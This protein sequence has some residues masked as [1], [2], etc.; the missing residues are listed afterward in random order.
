MKFSGEVKTSHKGLTKI[1]AQHNHKF[2]HIVISGQ[3]R[4]RILDLVIQNADKY[5]ASGKFV[6]VR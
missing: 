1:K 6:T 4:S 2:C 3:D 5:G